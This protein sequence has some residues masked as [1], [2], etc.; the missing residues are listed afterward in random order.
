[1]LTMG[2]RDKFSQLTLHWFPQK[3]ELAAWSH[4]SQESR[5]RLRWKPGLNI[6]LLL[7]VDE[8]NV[9]SFYQKI[10]IN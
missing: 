3:R 1:M 9:S 2:R 7:Q 8:L 10:Q 4:L 6:A 5:F